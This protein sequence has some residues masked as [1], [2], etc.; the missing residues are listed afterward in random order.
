MQPAA[1]YTTAGLKLLQ[2]TLN[3]LVSEEE[4]TPVSIAG[5]KASGP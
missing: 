3:F 2:G 1:N 4:A 5:W